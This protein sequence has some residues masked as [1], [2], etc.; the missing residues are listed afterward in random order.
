[1]DVLTRKSGVDTPFYTQ[2]WPVCRT[3]EHMTQPSIRRTYSLH[4]IMPASQDKKFYEML[5]SI[6]ET[7]GNEDAVQQNKRIKEAQIAEDSAEPNEEQIAAIHREV[8]AG[9]HHQPTAGSSKAR[10]Y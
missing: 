2:N 3:Q 9:K 7:A 6:A 4:L 5:D 1:M 10:N 8:E